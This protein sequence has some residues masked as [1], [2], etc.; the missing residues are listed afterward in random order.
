MS[1]LGQLEVLNIISISLKDI[2]RIK[3]QILLFKFNKTILSSKKI[4]FSATCC[5][6]SVRACTINL[7]ITFVVRF[8]ARCRWATYCRYGKKIIY[9]SKKFIKANF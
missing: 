1:E 5:R 3:S 4:L 9:Y 8:C 2:E 6:L 7:L